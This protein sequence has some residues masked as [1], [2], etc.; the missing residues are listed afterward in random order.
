MIKFKNC[1]TVIVDTLT[2][3]ITYEKVESIKIIEGKQLLKEGFEYANYNNVYYRLNF[4]DGSVA[5]FN[6]MFTHIEVL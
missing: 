2:M 1:K 5:T 6:T 3:C 4:E